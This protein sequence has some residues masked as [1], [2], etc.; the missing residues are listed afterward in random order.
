MLE[1]LRSWCLIALIIFLP[2][3]A[4][5]V[6]LTGQDILGLARDLLLTILIICSLFEWR[7]VKRPNAPTW[8]ALAFILLVL[9]SYWHR[10]DSPTQWLRGVRYLTEPMLLFTTLQLF[11]LSG[12]HQHL[13][14]ALKI[15]TSL[16][17]LGA[18][19][20]FFAPQA[21]R[22]T[23]DATSRGYLGQIHQA[24]S[25]TRLQSTLA[26]PNALGLFLVVSLLLWPVWSKSYSRNVTAG[27]GVLGLVA[28]L[29]TFSRSSY[30]G[31]FVGAVALLAAGRT[32]LKGYTKPLAISLLAVIVLVGGLY[33]FRPQALTRVNSNSVRL[34][35][36]QRLWNE[37]TT[38]GFWGRGAGAA[39]LVSVDRLDGGPNFYTENTYLDTYEAVGVLAALMYI[40]FWIS[41]IWLLLR[42]QTATNIAVGAAALGLAISGIFINHYT[43]QAAIWLVLL[44]MGLT[45]AEKSTSRQD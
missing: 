5:L 7:Q 42:S 6:S 13:W 8:L 26:G 38:I 14:R 30:L 36:Y 24:A 40:G 2:L 4:W 16:V 31:L 33:V 22:A 18:V 9:V 17:L 27:Y 28:T 45:V 29:L 35:Q 12:S 34:E 32:F 41:S 1:K 37:R 43:G 25:L 19:V 3:S 44:F 21:L 39:G 10:Q 23:I 20:E 11:P 15:A